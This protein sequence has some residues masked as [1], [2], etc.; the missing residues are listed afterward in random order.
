M[1]RHSRNNSISSGAGARSK[2][3]ASSVDDEPREE[4]SNV[5]NI[6]ERRRMQN[7]NA[8]R[9]YRKPNHLLRRRD[10]FL[11]ASQAEE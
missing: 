2:S 5:T 3:G 9:D 10:K 4:W 1:P 11:T 6:T 8:Q 7:R